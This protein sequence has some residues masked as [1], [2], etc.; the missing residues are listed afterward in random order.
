MAGRKFLVPPYYSQ[1]A[2]FASPL[3]AFSF[4][5]VYMFHAESIVTVNTEV[6]VIHGMVRRPTAK[7][8]SSGLIFYVSF[9]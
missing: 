7:G 2:V 4:N 3:S 5:D 8:V 1:R 9:P 6:S